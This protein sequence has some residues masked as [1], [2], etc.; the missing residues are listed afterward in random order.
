MPLKP[1]GE[2]LVG[3]D[4][5]AKIVQDIL[6]KSDLTSRELEFIITKL[7]DASYKGSEFEM[8]YAV[9]VKLTTSLESL[10]IKSK[11]Q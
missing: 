10:K 5:R 2:I 4:A 6:V 9:Y 3:E 11:G 8:F 7:K 1:N